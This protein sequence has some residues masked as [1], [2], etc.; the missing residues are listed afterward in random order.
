LRSDRENNFKDLEFVDFLH[1]AS[2]HFTWDWPHLQ[3]AQSRLE[4]VTSGLSSREMFFMPPRHGKSE[5]N[6]VHYAAYRIIKDPSTR[7][8]IAAYNQSL[9]CNFSRKVRRLVERFIP[10]SKEVKSV[11]H[12]ETTSEGGVRAVG[13]GSG[14]TGLGANLIIIDDPVKS[15]EEANSLHY[16]DRCWEWYTDDLWTRQEPDCSIMLTMT[17]WHGDDLGGRLQ[18]EADEDW[19]ITKLPALAKEDDPLGRELNEPL[20]PARMTKEKL[21][22]AREQ[23]GINFYALFQQEPQPPEGTMFKIEKL[24]KIHASLVPVCEQY[25][26]GWDKAAS[27]GK[28]DYTAGVLMGRY[29]HNYYIFRSIRGQW[30]PG[31]RRTQ[32]KKYIRMFNEAFGGVVTW[33]EEEGGSAGADSADLDIQEFAPHAVFSQKM[34][35]SKEARAMGFAAQVESEHVFIVEDPNNTFEFMDG[36]FIKDKTKNWQTGYIDE[37]AQFPFGCKNDD[38]VDASSLAFNKLALVEPLRFF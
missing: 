20:C 26:F 10:L 31:E 15:R 8:I 17:R 16:R 36:V 3:L 29:L 9:A 6:T 23:Q 35:G 18:Q 24:K 32:M 19:H 34:T 5:Q 33:I 7:V 13:V 27:A 1:R 22:I 28:G 25:V 14:V 12:W 4:L 2:P 21:I 37:L 30:S 11:D 38:Q